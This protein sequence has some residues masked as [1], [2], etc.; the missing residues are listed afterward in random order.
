[1][2]NNASSENLGQAANGDALRLIGLDEADEWAFIEYSAMDNVI[3]SGWV[4][5]EY[6]QI[7]LDGRP[8][9]LVALREIDASM[10]SPVGDSTRGGIN[11]SGDAEA[12]P[13]PTKDPFLGA[14]VGTVNLNPDANLHLR[15]RPNASTESLDLIPSGTRLIVDGVTE[16]GEWYTVSHD[17][18]AGWISAAFTVL[19]FNDRYMPSE[20]MLGRLKSFDDL[21]NEI[22]VEQTDDMADEMSEDTSDQ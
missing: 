18:V 6:V 20:E 12:P 15:I 3:I 9:T 1:M 5:A 21:G 14:V 19:S 10:I 2:A 22:P 11:L 4:S 8:I 13:V 17:G 16:S 7:L